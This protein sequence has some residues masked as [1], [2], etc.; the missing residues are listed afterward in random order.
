MNHK[1]KS[2]MPFFGG[3]SLLVIF[4]VLC[5]TIF[6]LMSLSTIRAEERLV[7]ASEHAVVSYYEADLKAEEIFAELRSGAVPESVV[8]TGNVYEY[9][10]PVTESQK[11]SV[12]LVNDKDEW[13]I[14]KWQC[15]STA[16]WQPDDT[17]VLL[18]P[19]AMAF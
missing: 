12:R 5:L 9:E 6:A 18:D 3:S 4:A 1:S 14:E 15:E 10:C 11:L 19:T 7:N 8:K 13:L 2:E 16:D 17:M